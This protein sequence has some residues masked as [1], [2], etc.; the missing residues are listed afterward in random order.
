MAQVR[1]QALKKRGFLR[2][3]VEAARASSSSLKSALLS[4]QGQVFSPSFKTGRI[5]ISQSGS[6]Q[7][8]SFLI[9]SNSVEWTQDNVFALTEELLG[10]HDQVVAAGTDESDLNAL[11]AAMT[12]ND[13]LADGV[14]CY[15]SDFTEMRC[16]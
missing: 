4:A 2:Q 10:L 15:T 14:D 8:G 9:P 1:I 5:V 13:L 6:G 11:F 12:A 7:S 3:I 16:A